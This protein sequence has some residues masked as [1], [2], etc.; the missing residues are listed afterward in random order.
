MARNSK[1]PAKKSGTKPAAPKAS[2]GRKRSWLGRI[3]Y[4]C[5]VLGLWG[6]I[7]VFGIFVWYAY[8][9]PDAT[10]LG[11]ATDRPVVRLLASDGSELAALGDLYG[12]KAALSTLPAHLPQAVLATE[13]RRFYDHFGVDLLGLL[14]ASIVNVRAG[15]IRQGGSTIT[16]QLAKNI[17]LTADRT[18]KR[19]VQEVLLALWLEY[20][21]SK[22]Q[23]LELYLN[24]VYLGA[25]T[26]GVE[27]ASRR[28]FNKGARKTGLAEAALLAGLLKAP[29][30]YAPTNDLKRS[31][32]RAAQ[33]LANM[34]DAGYISEAAADAAR[35][36]PARLN[37]GKAERRRARYF[38]DW[39]LEQVSGYIGHAERDLVIVSTLDSTMQ[40]AAEKALVAGLNGEGKKR[41]AGQGALISLA[42]DGAVR[43]MVGGRS[44]G[45]SQFNRAVQAQRQ[46]GSAFKLFVYAAGLE[47]GLTP[48]SRLRDEPVTIGDWSPR[49]YKPGFAGNIS[50]TE[51]LARSVNTI[52]VKV[53]E[54]AGRANVIGVAKRLGISSP[55]RAHPSIALGAAE[56]RL[57]DLT[58]AYAA[59]ANGGLGVWPYAI[60]EIRDGAGRVLFR[61]AGSGPGR[62]IDSGVASDLNRMLTAVVQSGT[63]RAA[64]LGRPAAGKTGTS[65]SFRDAWFV[66]YTSEFVTGV[67]IGNDD[68][69]PMKQVTGGGLPARV[70]KQFMVAA[71]KGRKARPLFEDRTP[72][73]IPDLLDRLIGSLPSLSDEPPQPSRDPTIWLDED[74]MRDRR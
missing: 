27:A 44:Y 51:A 69:A 45:Q 2:K 16:Q 23:I 50:L 13:D 36:R 54:R 73:S 31:R 67:W 61:R 20:N 62:V 8:D 6:L 9:L 72:K 59:V 63:G 58:A 15:R 11:R 66:G 39:A 42:P 22:D 68:G 14:R 37:P 64:R 57:A 74:A 4:W 3:V 19:K 21:Y 29:S 28:Y 70:W 46:P 18:L 26:Y 24:R 32:E 52:A 43:A 5:L 30:Y 33:V 10:Q 47:S 71:H 40:R 25:G 55:M 65:Q 56:V 35:K 48:Q 60:R 38:V 34:V 53:S 41:G 1:A 12:D 17:F 7:G 49:N